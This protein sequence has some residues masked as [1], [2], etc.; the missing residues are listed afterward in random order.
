VVL[1]DVLHQTYAIALELDSLEVLVKFLFAVLLALMEHALDQILAI[2]QALDTP[3]LYAKLPFATQHASTVETAF[4]L[5][6]VTAL[7]LD[8]IILIAK[9]PFA[10]THAF[11]EF[12]LDLTL[13]TVIQLDMEEHIVK[14]QFAHLDAP[15]SEFAPVQTP[16]TVPLPLDGLEPLAIFQFAQS[17]ANMEEIA[18]VPMFAA[19]KELDT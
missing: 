16:A 2:V 14:F 7:E 12:A 11:M 3:V 15:I 8:G 1:E 10:P 5:K 13:A 19:V 18:L 17:L 9:T 6:S 4:L